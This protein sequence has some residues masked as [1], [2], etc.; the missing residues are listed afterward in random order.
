MKTRAEFSPLHVEQLVAG[1][2]KGDTVAFDQL[3]GLYK[4]RVCAFVARRL[5]DPVEAEDIAQETFVKAYRHLPSFRGAS[6]FPTWLYR[7]AG[8]LTID[9]MRKRQRRGSNYSLDASPE[10]EGEPV[11]RQFAAPP[12]CEPEKGLETSE[13]RREVHRAIRDL[14]PKLRTVLVLYE[15]QGLNYREIAATLGCP[16]G[17]VKSRIFN[18]R[19][20]LK[21]SLLGSRA[22]E[23]LAANFVGLEGPE[24]ALS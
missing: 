20:E 15:L 6:S 11:V 21:R 1:S 17:T 13:L 9:S 16:V 2:R 5:S 24:V 23:L 3:V 12:S 19:G 7:I 4:D 22:R 18:A 10:V 14:A 8:N